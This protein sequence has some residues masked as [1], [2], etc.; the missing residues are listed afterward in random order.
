MALVLFRFL[1][2][3]WSR[4]FSDLS[5]FFLFKPVPEDSG[6]AGVSCSMLR[7]SNG[8]GWCASCSSV[9]RCIPACW[10]Y[11]LWLSRGKVILSLSS[12]R[13]FVTAPRSPLRCL[14]S[15]HQQPILVGMGVLWPGTCV[16]YG[17][18]L[19]HLS[20]AEMLE[21]GDGVS[22]AQTCSSERWMGV[23]SVWVWVGVSF[24]CPVSAPLRSGMEEV[25]T[26][27]Q[28]VPDEV[29]WRSFRPPPF[30][31]NSIHVVGVRSRFAAGLRRT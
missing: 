31:A 22:G 4:L 26:F 19:L 2:S 5:F 25:V 16:V 29:G 14:W 13:R 28:V 17:S 21:N 27:V 20:G 15:G 24:I 9:M 10:L 1:S 11:H 6:C 3:N 18:G 30:R 7:I 12:L 8:V 23:S